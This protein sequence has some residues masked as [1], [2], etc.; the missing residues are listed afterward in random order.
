MPGH[1]RACQAIPGQARPCHARPGHARPDQT[2]PDQTS[3]PKQQTRKQASKASEKAV[4]CE[5]RALRASSSSSSSSS[6]SPLPPLHPFPCLRTGVIDGCPSLQRS[7]VPR[8]GNRQLRYWHRMSLLYGELVNE[9]CVERRTEGF[10]RVLR[11]AGIKEGGREKFRK[12]YETLGHF[13]AQRENGRR[14]P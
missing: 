1:A 12:I 5:R 14:E 10:S 13:G 9:K 8:L 2:R 6:S 7:H 3:Q 11:E 4:S